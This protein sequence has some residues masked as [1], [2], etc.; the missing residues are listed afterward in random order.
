M[1]GACPSL[2][3]IDWHG[4]RGCSGRRW[5]FPGALLHTVWSQTA[6]QFPDHQTMRVSVSLQSIH[7]TKKVVWGR[8]NSETTSVKSEAEAEVAHGLDGAICRQEL[9]ERVSERAVRAD[10]TAGTGGGGRG[11]GR[12]RREDG[13][14]TVEELRERSAECLCEQR[15]ITIRQIHVL[16]VRRETLQCGLE[17][18]RSTLDSLERAADRLC[19]R[20]RSKAGRVGC[21]RTCMVC[22]RRPATSFSLPPTARFVSEERS[23]S[24]PSTAPLRFV[25]K[26]AAT[27]ALTWS[28]L[29]TTEHVS[30]G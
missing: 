7:E 12:G 26:P 27:P 17:C 30:G 20:E 9:A 5:L 21:E 4:K 2:E 18:R 24:S 23:P 14:D 3:H 13:V 10:A 29:A 11:R 6:M 8:A 15:C 25:E 19:Q 28:G 1:L 22:A 16:G